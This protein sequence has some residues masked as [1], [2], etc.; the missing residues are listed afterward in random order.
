MFGEVEPRRGRGSCGGL[1]PLL[2]GVGARR[3]AGRA[4]LNADALAVDRSPSEAAHGVPRIMS[5]ILEGRHGSMMSLP[6]SARP[7]LESSGSEC[8]LLCACLL[9]PGP[10]DH[11]PRRPG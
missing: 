10:P 6:G 3:R 5:L 7:S 4:E 8:R 11:P 1:E 2:S 9:H